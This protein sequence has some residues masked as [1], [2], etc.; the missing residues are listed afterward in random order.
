MAMQPIKL[1]TGGFCVCGSALVQ[2][3]AGI[4][5]AVD[6]STTPPTLAHLRTFHDSAH[7]KIYPP[8][9]KNFAKQTKYARGTVCQ[10]ELFKHIQGYEKHTAPHHHHHKWASAVADLETLI[11]QLE[12]QYPHW[13]PDAIKAAK[14]TRTLLRRQSAS[15]PVKAAKLTKKAMLKS[16]TYLQK[17]KQ[18]L[19]D[20]LTVAFPLSNPA[21]NSNLINGTWY[22]TLLNKHFPFVRQIPPDI[23]KGIKTHG[24]DFLDM[25]T[26]I[27]SLPNR[28][29]SAVT[30]AKFIDTQIQALGASRNVSKVTAMLNQSSNRILRT[31]AELQ[32]FNTDILNIL[33]LP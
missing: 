21:V 29:Q 9:T 15:T 27:V 23:A 28:T 12:N 1:K 26:T 4:L 25:I 17:N 8:K 7:G 20:I 10:G 2:P 11:T 16:L 14:D 30:I 22:V 31:A 6:T 32:T 18:H 19:A 3:V 33:R 5:Y 24:T 13:T